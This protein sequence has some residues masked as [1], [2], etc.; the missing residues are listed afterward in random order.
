MQELKRIAR[1][2]LREGV[3]MSECIEPTLVAMQ[4]KESP[5][6]TVEHDFTHMAA[7]LHARVC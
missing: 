7:R 4:L 3:P 2:A 5:S 6:Q 1:K